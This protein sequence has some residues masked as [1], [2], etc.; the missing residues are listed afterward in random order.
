MLGYWLF[1]QVEKGK[2]AFWYYKTGHDKKNCFIGELEV[3]GSEWIHIPLD[4]YSWVHSYD[5]QYMCY[6]TDKGRKNIEN[7]GKQLVPEGTDMIHKIS[8]Q[9]GH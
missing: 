9:T 8:M 2:G 3:I 5:T 4:D 6:S 1:A 7:C